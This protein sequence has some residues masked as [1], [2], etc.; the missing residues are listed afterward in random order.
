MT[1]EKKV[2][3][4]NETINFLFEF[5]DINVFTKNIEYILVTEFV[6]KAKK[7]GKM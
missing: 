5:S 2:A 3:F 6:N 1:R 7:S 4:S